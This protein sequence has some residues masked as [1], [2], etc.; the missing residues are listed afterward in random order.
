MASHRPLAVIVGSI[1]SV[2]DYF[3][4]HSKDEPSFLP[5]LKVANEVVGLV[6]SGPLDSAARQKVQE[7]LEGLVEARND[8]TGWHH[9][10]S[11]LRE[12]LEATEAE[13]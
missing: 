12:W 6:Q 9:F 11:L 8:G 3:A 13:P 10:K 5:E 2:R 4:E 1:C 7:A